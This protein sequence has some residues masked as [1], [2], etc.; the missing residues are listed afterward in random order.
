MATKKLSLKNRK[1]I[2]DATVKFEEHAKNIKE[3]LGAPFDVTFDGDLA[4]LYEV[5]K[6]YTVERVHF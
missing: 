1:D 5:I 6:E 4:E 3:M 2:R